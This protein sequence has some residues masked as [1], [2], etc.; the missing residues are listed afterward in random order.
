MRNSGYKRSQE[1]KIDAYQ[2]QKI[3]MGYIKVFY[4]KYDKLNFETYTKINFTIKL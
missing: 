2:C 4:K 1:I 3:R